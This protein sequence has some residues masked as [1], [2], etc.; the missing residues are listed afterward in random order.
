MILMKLIA[1]GKAKC[2]YVENHLI[3]IKA[4]QVYMLQA[5]NLRWELLWEY[6]DS[7]S[8]GHSSIH[9]LIALVERN[10]YWPDLRENVYD[11]V[12]AFLI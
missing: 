8:V 5:N 9:K 12:M 11:Y 10:F 7:L 1:K 4:N 3:L 2:F 6:H